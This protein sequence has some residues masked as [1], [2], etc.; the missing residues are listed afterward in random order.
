MAEK[1]A[2]GFPEAQK[3]LDGYALFNNQIKTVLKVI[4]DYRL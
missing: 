3:R 4:Y 1:S 2:T